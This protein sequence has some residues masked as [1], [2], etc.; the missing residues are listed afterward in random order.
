MGVSLKDIAVQLNLSK[1]TV[2]WV[3][4]GQGDRKGISPETQQRVMRR[5]RELAYE[6]NL[7]ARSL[8][9]GVSKTIGLILPSIS[10][11]FYARVAQRIETEAEKAGY[12]LMIAGS[13][14]QIERE[15]AMLRL[16]RSKKAD[17]III[18]P[19]QISEHEILRTID[20]DYPIV[21]LGRYFSEVP[22]D[23][24]VINDRESSYRLVH[25]LVA[26]GCRKIA[27]L[28]PASRLPTMELRRQGY[29]DALSDARIQVDPA[30]SAEVSVVDH[31]LHVDRALDRIFE[32]VPDV[33]GFF[34][35][36]H[37]LASEAL[38]YFHDRGIDYNRLGLACMH[39]DPLFRILAPG[40]NVARFPV[41]EI[42]CQAVRMILDRID[43][44]H[45]AKPFVPE[46]K[47]FAC[48]LDFSEE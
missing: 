27:I 32:T 35:A 44:K 29:A 47:V 13:N 9:S 30:L 10:D 28:T 36:T 21:L 38:R 33:D 39:E 37:I 8:N 43:G 42:G 14:S 26:G 46:A 34:F 40:M 5:A 48:E 31:R 6:P 11:G 25:R 45:E 18:A 22:I 19:T 3:L 16:F 20:N 15:T 1:T 41:E 17:G 23:R 24:I 4:S 12:S 2:S 7:L